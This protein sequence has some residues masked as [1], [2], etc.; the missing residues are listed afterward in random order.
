M[1]TLVISF[2]LFVVTELGEDEK[3]NSTA[4]EMGNDRR[5]CLAFNTSSII[6]PFGV[7]YV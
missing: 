1:R 5:D 6:I 2:L 7:M 4:E 3:I